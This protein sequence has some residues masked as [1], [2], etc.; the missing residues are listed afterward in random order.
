MTKKKKQFGQTV[1]REEHIFTL[2]RMEL[3]LKKD[4]VAASKL[5]LW[6][7]SF[8]FLI[9]VAAVLSLVGQILEGLRP[10]L[11]QDV[12]PV[13][14]L[15]E[16]LN[17]GQFGLLIWALAATLA[18]VSLKSRNR[19]LIRKL[20]YVRKELEQNDATHESSGLTEFGETPDE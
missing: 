18:G 11:G 2:R 1:S 9:I 16:A 19:K 3:E 8:K 6:H 4:E 17:L 5:E 14:Q 13:V 15:V 7:L 12:S 20:N 10:Y